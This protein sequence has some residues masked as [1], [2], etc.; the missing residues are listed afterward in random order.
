MKLNKEES[1]LLE[2]VLTSMVFDMTDPGKRVTGQAKVLLGALKKV[3][4]SQVTT[5]K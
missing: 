5:K 4:G 2:Q 1:R 3:K